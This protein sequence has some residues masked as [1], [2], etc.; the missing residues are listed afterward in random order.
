MYGLPSEDNDAGTIDPQ[1]HYLRTR[2]APYF[3]IRRKKAP[4][5][6]DGIFA[7]TLKVQQQLDQRVPVD[8]LCFA[9]MQKPPDGRL[10]DRVD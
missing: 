7:A 5:R 3:A 9:S 4:E 6:S 10:P 8:G 2:T 1:L